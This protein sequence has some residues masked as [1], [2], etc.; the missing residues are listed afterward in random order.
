MPV[1]AVCNFVYAHHVHLI[2]LRSD[3]PSEEREKFDGE[4]YERPGDER[5]LRLRDYMGERDGD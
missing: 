3:K 2:D 4:L 5:V 1:R